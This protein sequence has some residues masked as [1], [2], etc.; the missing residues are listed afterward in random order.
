MKEGK[1]VN[2]QNEEEKEENI[3]EGDLDFDDYEEGNTFDYGANKSNG[4][5]DE[6]E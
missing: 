1:K 2:F 5:E 3:N 6:S 4:D